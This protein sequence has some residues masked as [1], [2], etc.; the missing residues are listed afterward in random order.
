[1][2]LS[3]M[4]IADL[5]V[6]LLLAGLGIVLLGSAGSGGAGGR[7]LTVKSLKGEIL[8]HDLGRDAELE[9]EGLIGTTVI[10]VEGRKA[11]FT[12]SPCKHKL[13]V[14]RG[15]IGRAGEWVLCLPNGVIAEISG[16]DE[17][18]GITP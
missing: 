18:D 16:E 17:Y 1:M 14:G 5:V 9:I 12:S 6:I 15:R 13:C 8:E 2:M 7:V 4:T 3:K 10:V 11:A